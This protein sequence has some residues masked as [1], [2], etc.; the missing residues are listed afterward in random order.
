MKHKSLPTEPQVAS[1]ILMVRPANFGFNPET[2]ED[3]AFQVDDGSMDPDEVQEA[4]ASEFDAFVDTLRKAGLDIIVV[5][6]SQEPVKTDAIFPN[7]WFTTHTSGRLIVYPMFARGRRAERRTDVVDMLADNFKVDF[8]DRYLSFER[9]NQFLEGTGSMILDRPNRIV[10]AC[11]SERTHQDLLDRW[12]ADHGY[13]VVAFH[14]C[15]QEGIPYYHTNV[16]M[17]LGTHFALIC[18]ESI[19]DDV[20][21]SNLTSSLNRTGKVIVEISRKQVLQFAGNA[22]EVGS[23]EGNNILV[24]SES[25]YKSLTRSQI[26]ILQEFVEILYSPLNIIEKYGGGSARCMMA[27]IFLP[28]K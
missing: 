14:A 22:L 12:A 10:Y 16:I 2:A 3:N 5:E 8:D 13:D 17:T 6:D 24:M 11:I 26:A 4:A 23:V 7:N 25:A 19:E 28:K 1:T 20:E 21:R 18:L 27:E 9:G 15:D